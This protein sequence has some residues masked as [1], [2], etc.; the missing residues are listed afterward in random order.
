M[1]P[2]YRRTVQLFSN[3]GLTCPVCRELPPSDESEDWLVEGAN[4]LIAAHGWDVLHVGQ[5]VHLDDGGFVQQTTIA[6]GEPT[7]SRLRK[8]WARVTHAGSAQ[9]PPV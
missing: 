5:Q 1:A 9:E 7:R 4:H 2:N 3:M 8:R 6:L